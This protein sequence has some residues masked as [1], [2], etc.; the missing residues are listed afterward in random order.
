MSALILESTITCPQCGHLKTETMPTDACQWFY[1]C[2]AC[3]QLLKPLLGDYCVNTQITS[4]HTF[5]NDW[6]ASIQ[7]VPL[8]ECRLP[9]ERGQRRGGVP[10]TFGP[11][12]F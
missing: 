7:G 1:Q 9:F 11:R 3:M 12:G 6:G 5:Q 2:E 4:K 8:K 10:Q